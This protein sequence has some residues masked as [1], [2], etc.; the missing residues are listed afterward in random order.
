MKLT[1]KGKNA[2]TAM[3]DL[4]LYSNNL[5]IS[6][7]AINQRQGISVHYLEQLFNKLKKSK[8]VN[9]VR[10]P[11]G[12]YLLTRDA[13]DIKI[14]EIIN[15]VEDNFQA[16][17]CHGLENCRDGKKC[18]GHNLWS[19]LNELLQNYLS[20]LSLYDAAHQCPYHKISSIPDEY[21]PILNNLHKN[22]IKNNNSI[23]IKIP[24][25]KS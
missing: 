1:T 12:G 22:N 8:L 10:G 17:D 19:E 6:L 7:A 15:A 23:E 18:I 14:A 4:C 24:G 21:S 3:L 11:N 9:S 13:K 25:D 20:S 2:V 16:T 5:P